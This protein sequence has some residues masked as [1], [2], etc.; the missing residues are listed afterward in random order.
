ML[1]IYSRSAR[2]LKETRLAEGDYINK[3]PPNYS[4]SYV[5]ESK[6]L[7]S[8]IV[9]RTHLCFKDYFI[10]GY[11]N[12]FFGFLIGTFEVTIISAVK[13]LITC[14]VSEILRKH[15]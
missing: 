14:L 15:L 8:W 6:N 9:S 4:S 5:L 7:Y 1:F 13:L 3:H 2:I 12:I 10:Q 11:G